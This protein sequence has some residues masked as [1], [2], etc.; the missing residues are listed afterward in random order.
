MLKIVRKLTIRY[1]SFPRPS[2]FAVKAVDDDPNPLSGK[3]NFNHF[4]LR[5]WYIK[6][7]LWAVWSPGA[8][9]LRLFGGRAPTVTGERYHPQGYDLM[10]I[11]PAPQEGNGLE[12]MKTNI[13]MM[14]ARES[15]GCPFSSRHRIA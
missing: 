11:G 7:S 5:P 10:T 4:G 2:S 3:F 9:L 6:P 14:K 12:E 1:L 13:S 15:V 8:L